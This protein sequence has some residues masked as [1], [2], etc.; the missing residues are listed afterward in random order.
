MASFNRVILAGH[1]THDPAVRFSPS[2]GTQ[3]TTLGL[4]VNTSYG[5]GETRKETTCFVDVIAFGKL[6]ETTSTYVQKGRAVLVEG[7]LHW[8]SWEGPDGQKRS[9]H[10][11][12]AER[13]E[14]LD[15]PSGNG[16]QS[17]SRPQATVSPQGNTPFCPTHGALKRSAKGAGWFCPVKLPDGTWCKSTGGGGPQP[18]MVSAAPS[19]DADSPQDGDDDIPF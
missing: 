17:T 16:T 3:V 15:R 19:Q 1:L 18:A 4:A 8:R 9:K 13:I 11:V 6:A 5:S 10:E 7:R 12:I 14:F 2:S